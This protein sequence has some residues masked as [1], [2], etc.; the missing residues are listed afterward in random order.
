MV[1]DIS[2]T[3]CH[4]FQSCVSQIMR[5]KR[6]K[7]KLRVIKIQ[8]DM[9]RVLIRCKEFAYFISFLLKT[10]PNKMKHFFHVGHLHFE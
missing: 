7:V 5:E 3:P 4:H 6:A 1:T 2:M 9:Q 8:Y 10:E